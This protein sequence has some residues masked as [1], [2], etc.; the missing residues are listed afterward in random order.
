[1]R[2]NTSSVY[3]GIS[4]YFSSVK[5]LAS[6]G[7]M[8]RTRAWECLTGKKEFTEDEKKAIWNAILV[9]V[10]DISSIQ[11]QDQVLNDIDSAFKKVD[12]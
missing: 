12:F 6:A 5:E 10:Y 4:R 11:F 3:P 1:M 2:S 8:S 9:K 7:C